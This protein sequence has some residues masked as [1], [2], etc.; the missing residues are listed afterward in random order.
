LHSAIK[1][2]KSPLGENESTHHEHIFTGEHV[3]EQR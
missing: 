2:L 1:Y 3:D